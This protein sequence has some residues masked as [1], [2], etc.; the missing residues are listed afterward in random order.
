MQ[1]ASQPPSGFAST[2]P[3]W[4]YL[5]SVG[6]KR[7]PRDPDL[8][9]HMHFP[10]QA[11][12]EPPAALWALHYPVPAA[13]HIVILLRLP[14]QA[15][16]CWLISASILHAVAERHGMEFLSLES[17][18]VLPAGERRRSWRDVSMEWRAS[19]LHPIKGMGRRVER[20]LGRS[21]A[22]WTPW[23]LSF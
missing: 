18:L 8:A 15:Q 11:S 22:G 19:Q 3:L 17:R 13:A 20:S 2:L 10:T 9:L 4:Q 21:Q 14:M 1:P 16:P 6:S 7:V 5:A 23:E 12:Q